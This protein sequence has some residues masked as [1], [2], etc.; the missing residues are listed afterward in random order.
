[1]E[2]NL[3]FSQGHTKRHLLRDAREAA[4]QAISAFL[5]LL[6]FALDKVA[7]MP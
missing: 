6:N 1:M 3:H 5:F 7:I 4:Y 2:I